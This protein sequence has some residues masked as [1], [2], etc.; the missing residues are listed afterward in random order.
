MRGC[1]EEG[2]ERRW[3][4]GHGVLRLSN[5]GRTCLVEVYVTGRGG[6]RLE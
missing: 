4:G 3:G 1:L 6:A 5:L 2:G